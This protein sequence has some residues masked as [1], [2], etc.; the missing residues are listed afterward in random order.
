MAKRKS[1]DGAVKKKKPT[2]FKFEFYISLEGAPYVPLN[3][4]SPSERSRAEQKMVENFGRAIEQSLCGQREQ[5]LS[6]CEEGT[7]VDA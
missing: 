1:T 5:W 7:L 2:G 6:L 4:L 3:S